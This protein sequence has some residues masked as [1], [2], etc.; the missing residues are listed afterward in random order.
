MESWKDCRGTD[1]ELGRLEHELAERDQ[2][3][4]E[5]TVALQTLKKNGRIQ[6]TKAIRRFVQSEKRAVL[7]SVRLTSVLSIFG[8]SN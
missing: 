5:M 3:I 7:G 4:G 8:I 6:V 1:L 2:M